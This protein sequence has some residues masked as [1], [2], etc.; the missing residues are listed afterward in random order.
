MENEPLSPEEEKRI[1]GIA[2]SMIIE[3]KSRRSCGITS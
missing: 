2:A 3:E 1:Y